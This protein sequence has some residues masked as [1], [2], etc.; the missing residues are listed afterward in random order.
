MPRKDPTFTDSDL[1][2]FYCRNVDPGEKYRVMEAFKGHIKK[3]IK[4]CPDDP[5]KKIDPCEWINFSEWL[6]HQCAAKARLLVQIAQVLTMLEVALGA[7]SWLPPYGKVLKIIVVV[8][9]YVVSVLIFAATLMTLVGQ[10]GGFMGMLNKYFCTGEEPGP[11][12]KP[13]GLDLPEDPERRMDE[14]V[15]WI[16]S[17]FDWLSPSDTDNLPPELLP[18]P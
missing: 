7:L 17:I 13:P 3:G 10:L 1:L 11:L 9:G 15:N 2:R 5:E 16:E 14:I 8:L 6:V 12:P 18:G 4:I